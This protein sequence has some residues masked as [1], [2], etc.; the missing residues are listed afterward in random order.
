MNDRIFRSQLRHFVTLVL[1]CTATFAQNNTIT[2]VARFP[3][4][5]SPLTIRQSA[6]AEKPFSVTGETGAILG[7]QDG[8]CEL[9]NFPVRVFTHLRL[10]ADVQGY[11]VPIELNPLAA[12]IEVAP[13]H[14]TI[15][16][17]HAA[18]TVRQHMFLAHGSKDVQ[19]P[20]VL[21]EIH[22]VRP[23]TLIVSVDPVLERMWPALNGGRPDAAWVPLGSGGG[24]ELE[25]SDPSLAAMVAM[26][27]AQ[28]GN[29]PSFQETS[30]NF[31]LQFKVSYAPGQDDARYFPLLTSVADDLPHNAN[32]TPILVSQIAST[33]AQLS[34]LYRGDDDY[35][36][37]FFDH[38]LTAET[39]DATFDQTL[40]WAE[41]SM[42][43]LKVRKGA[44]IGLVAGVLLAQD[45]QRPGFGWF[46]G[47]DTLWSIYAI[48]SE[49]DLAL[50]RDALEFLIARQRSDGKIMHEYSQTADRVDWAS[51]GFEYAAADATPLFIMA[52]DDYFRSSGDRDFLTRHWE[53]LQR[54]YAFTRAHETG[55]IYDNTQGTGWVESWSPKLPHQ[56]LYLAALDQQ[57]C[58]SM[59]ELARMMN[60]TALAQSAQQ[61]AEAIRRELAGFLGPDG[62]YSFARNLDGSYDHTR[63]VY[64]AVAWWTGELALP[65]AAKTLDFYAGSDLS[66]DWGARAI[67]ASDPLYDPISYHQG[68]VWPLFTGWASMAEYRSGRP[69]AGLQ[70]LRENVGLTWASDPGNVTELLSGA[71]DATFGRSTA[72]QLWS[73]AMVLTPAVRGLFGVEADVPHHSLILT[74]QLPPEWPTA[75]LHHVPFGNAEL[76]IVF[77]RKN[78]ELEVT[79]HSAQPIRLCLVSRKPTS[80]CLTAPASV[81]TMQVLLPD[82]QAILPE[83]TLR[84]GDSSHALRIVHEEYGMRTLSL[85]LQA[86]AGSEQVIPLKINRPGLTRLAANGTV[87]QQTDLHVTFPAGS[88][89][90]QQVVTI[91]W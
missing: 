29:M 84:P 33:A 26:P 61:Q 68:S 56:E 46:F 20:V 53:S 41:I 30:N 74:P 50:S 4:A 73:S 17:S 81:H 15:T 59:A 80:D 69:L 27:N 31:P 63:T 43:Q 37:H 25:N 89:F 52:M 39:P 42:D 83:S 49:G 76:D 64:P 55:G 47:R 22:A 12:T 66:A 79:V 60:D 48:D 45:S 28:P 21:F 2:P 67:A 14:T 78:T 1:F 57:S 85:T 71:F 10:T 82:V 77:Q 70:H 32:P 35:Y 51:L 87:L 5:C 90:Q 13:D 36:V 24:Y 62:I 9:W 72:H 11:G 44:E 23:M 19:S 54:A 88:G 34:E 3:F 8:S 7:M 16:Y 91:T 40:R 38:R 58:A 18:V 6:Q 65:N 86:P 75:T